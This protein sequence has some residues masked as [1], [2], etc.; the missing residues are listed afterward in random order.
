MRYQPDRDHPAPLLLQQPLR[1]LPDLFRAR[2]ADGRRPEKVVP[3]PERSILAG[4]VAPWPEGSKSWRLKMVDTLA[5][6]MGFSL[7]T[8]WKKL[9]RGAREVILQ[10]SGERRSPSADRQE[11]ELLLDRQVRGGH[12]DARPGATR[13]PTRRRS[14]PRSRSSCRSPLPDLRGA[15]AAA[16]GAG[17]E[18]ARPV[19]RRAVA[20]VGRPSCR[21][22]IAWLP[23]D[24]RERRDRRRRCCK[25]IHDRLASSTTSALGYLTLDRVGRHALRRREPAHPAGDADRQRADGRALRARRAVDRPAPAR[26]RRACSPPS[27][28]MRD[29]GN[30]VLVVEHD[31]ETIRAA[32]WVVDFGPGAGVHGGEVVAQGTPRQV[33]QSPE[34][35]T[36]KYLTR[37]PGGAGA[38]SAGAPR[39][40][41]AGDQGGAA[42]QPQGPRRSTSRSALF[43]A[44]TGVSGSGKSTLVNDI[45]HKAL[46]R[47]FYR[48][49]DKPGAHD[50][51]LGLDAA[52]Q[53]DRHR[54]EPD[55]PHA[56]LEPGDLHQGLRPD[57]QP[58]R[59]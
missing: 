42:E 10:G 59:R 33:E 41:S 38:A 19:D 46:A 37:R 44:V 8:P 2:H 34:S 48:A 30:S 28:G 52:R 16:G 54:P 14:A 6:A 11:V 29:L 12:P 24:K 15:A 5:K 56:A 25:E 35:L 18:G 22:C 27:S 57:P 20:P 9:P 1:R 36:G 7:S 58:V 49:A 26:Q 39:R 40:A 23:L 55:R 3:D 43:V 45:L 47:H 53:G 51:I 31:E 4:A 50:R 17:G 13:R 32:D 21:A